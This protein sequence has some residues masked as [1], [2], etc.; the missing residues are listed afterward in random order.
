MNEVSNVNSFIYDSDFRFYKA[1]GKAHIHFKV[2]EISLAYGD[3]ESAYKSLNKATA[4]DPQNFKE[5]SLSLINQFN[6]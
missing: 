5:K 2:A 4:L 1:S 3:K 6:N